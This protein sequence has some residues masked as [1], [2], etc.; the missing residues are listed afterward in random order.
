M[1][2]IDHDVAPP[3]STFTQL[4]HDTANAMQPGDSVAFDNR[5]RAKN[6]ERVL[7]A[8]A[9]QGGDMRVIRAQ[10]DTNSWRVWL[11]QREG[12]AR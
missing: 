9:C 4:A 2:T 5:Y 10:V 1:F 6:F 12:I 3:P 8:V 11:V 7:R